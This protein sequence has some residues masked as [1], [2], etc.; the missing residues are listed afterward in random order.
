MHPVTNHTDW[1]SSITYAIKK[2][3]SLRVCLDP[4][5]LNQALK[6]CPHKNTTVEEITPAFTKAKCFT[7]LDAKAS[8]WSVQLVPSSQ[9]PTTFQCP[10]GRYCFTR[11]PFGLCV[12]QDLFQR[13]MDRIIDQ[14]EGAVGISDDLM[15]YEDTEEQHD[16]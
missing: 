5:K 2:D 7:K 1:C 14:C 13:H 3:G 9:E 8:Y 12:S 6:R 16:K 11:L 4:Q 10:F 15:V